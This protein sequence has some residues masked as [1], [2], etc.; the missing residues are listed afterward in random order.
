MS[1]RTIDLAN[2]ISKVLALGENGD[3]DAQ[4]LADTLE[5]IE[6]MIEDKFDATMSVIKDFEAKQEA[7]KKEATRL[8]ERAKH[9]QRQAGSL[10]QYL[11]E[12]LQASGRKQ[13]KS[14]LHTYSVKKGSVSLKI[15]DEDLIPDEFVESRTQVIHDIQKDKIKQILTEALKAIEDLHEK[16]EQVPEELLNKVPGAQVERGPESLS[17]R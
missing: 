9:W 4:T 2:E 11:L 6:G 13:F 15:V 5:G 1:N 14:T 16:G 12:C 10:R 7:C 8:T 17:V 3:I